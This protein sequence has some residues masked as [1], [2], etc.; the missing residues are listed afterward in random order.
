MLSEATR[1][2]SVLKEWRKEPEPLELLA[3]LQG[4]TIDDEMISQ[5]GESILE[6]KDYAHS[7]LSQIK[8]WLREVIPYFYKMYDEAQSK[9]K[10][11]VVLFAGRDAR[12]LFTFF[13][14]QAQLRG[15]DHGLFVQIPGSRDFYADKVRD[16]ELEK[17][18]LESFGVTKERLE[19]GTEYV[20]VDTGFVGSV[21]VAFH[22][23]LQ[24]VLSVS[25][26]L[27][28][29]VQILLVSNYSEDS[30]IAQFQDFGPTQNQMKFDLSEFVRWKR[31]RGSTRYLYTEKFSRINDFVAI[32]MQNVPQYHG[33]YDH[34]EI[35]NDNPIAVS[36]GRG[37]LQKDMAFFV[38][39]ADF[40]N[41]VAAL[42]IDIWMISKMIAD[43][44]NP[45]A[46]RVLELEKSR[47]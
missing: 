33:A 14:V 44:L 24:Q 10:G 9:H 32:V 7:D 13:K 38:I 47:I 16:I 30:S 29:A 40:I 34:T 35:Y 31:E 3:L 21:G 8:E 20:F 18:L 12:I 46:I 22:K 11:K 39:N 2:V 5:V 45:S 19:A 25:E 27:A 23:Y 6:L 28:K 17:K 41:P 43:A 15:D 26:E 4:G 42:R 37:K 36:N 1:L